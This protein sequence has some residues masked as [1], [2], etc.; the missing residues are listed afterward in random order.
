MNR[1]AG[2]PA[3]SCPLQ[4]SPSGWRGSCA[5]SSVG[6][7]APAPAAA[8]TPAARRCAARRGPWPC[9]RQ[10][11]CRRDLHQH[12]LHV[13]RQAGRRKSGQL[14]Q[15]CSTSSSHSSSKMQTG[16]TCQD[17][18]DP[19]QV[20]SCHVAPQAL[21]NLVDVLPP[22]G[23]GGARQGGAGR[24]R[25]GTGSGQGKLGVSRAGTADIV[26]LSS[27]DRVSNKQLRSSRCACS[28]RGA[29]CDSLVF[30]IVDKVEQ[31]ALQRA[32]LRFH[33][34]SCT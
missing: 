7:A 8:R 6:A 27:A 9:A 20:V 26:K 34:H 5:G 3:G 24:G 17:V 10:C 28:A 2:K 31:A 23:Q 32:A 25:H 4:P 14:A 16:G 21:H 33:L 22:A 15:P 13:G 29:C 12:K 18:C 11:A 30:P 1:Q 19:V